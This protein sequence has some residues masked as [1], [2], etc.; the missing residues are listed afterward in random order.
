M[1]DVQLESFYKPEV[2][3]L[4]GWCFSFIPVSAQII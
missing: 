1:L 2:L 4:W 3:F